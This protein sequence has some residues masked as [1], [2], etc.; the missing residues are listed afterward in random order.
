M[1]QVS[2]RL[3][4]RVGRD[5]FPT[6]HRA[7]WI[8]WGGIKPVIFPPAIVAALQAW[9]VRPRFNTASELAAPLLRAV[10]APL[11]LVT[12]MPRLSFPR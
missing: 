8:G 6:Y 10:P 7:W 5:E 12:V 3:F 4:A 1:V 2:W 9:V 11:A